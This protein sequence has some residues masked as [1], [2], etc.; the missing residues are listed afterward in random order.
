MPRILRELC[1]NARSSFRQIAKQTGLSAP[2]VED[3]I[4]KMT[5]AGI[6]LGYLPILNIDKILH[7]TSALLQL[8]VELE[9][10]DS[11]L[12]KLAKLNEVRSVLRVTGEANILLR[13]F[14]PESKDLESFITAN[15][16]GNNG[17][18]I[19]SSQIITQTIKEEPGAIIDENFSIKLKCDYCDREILTTD[20]IIINVEEGKRFLCCTSCEQLYRSK[21]LTKKPITQTFA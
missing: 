4:Q 5:E 14:L 2:T 21:Y 7:S 18:R 6:I 11:F 20:A 10:M 12:K 15:I 19:L 8:H 1:K 16:A 9:G 17:V 13:I 3:H